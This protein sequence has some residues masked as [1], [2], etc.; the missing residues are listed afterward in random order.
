MLTALPSTLTAFPSTLTA[1]PST[2]SA[3][4]GTASEALSPG[5]LA[6][7]DRSEVLAALLAS[8]PCVDA[9]GTGSPISCI[10]INRDLV[11]VGGL[12]RVVWLS[13]PH[14]GL[15]SPLPPSTPTPQVYCAHELGP[16]VMVAGMALG[17]HS[18]C[19]LAV[20]TSDG[21]LMSLKVT[22]PPPAP[23]QPAVL[24]DDYDVHGDGGFLQS[25][26]PLQPTAPPPPPVAAHPPTEQQLVDAHV[27]PVAA[28]MPHPCAEAVVRGA[29]ALGNYQEWAKCWT[30]GWAG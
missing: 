1:L 14:P 10:S 26:R 6:V 9:M 20:G 11:V 22:P 27:G 21:R 4:T 29:G 23:I 2:L 13:R 15:H 30:S 25:I 7:M 17:G 28:L 16:A 19:T 8:I 18:L 3:V 24:Q 5:P 12:E